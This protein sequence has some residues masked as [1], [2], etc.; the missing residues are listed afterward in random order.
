[1]AR[2]GLN[3]PLF[4]FKLSR[5]LGVLPIAIAIHTDE[6]QSLNEISSFCWVLLKPPTIRRQD[7]QLNEVRR[8]QTPARLQ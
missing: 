5:T 8:R 4:E 2:L 3:L 1:L 6:I 7:S